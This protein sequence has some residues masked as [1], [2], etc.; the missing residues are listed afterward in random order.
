MNPLLTGVQLNTPTT[1][2]IITPSSIFVGNSVTNTF[3]NSSY[4][5]I[6]TANVTSNT[7]TLGTSTNAANGY[8]Y[9][10]N[11]FKM[12]WGWI[13]ANSSDGNVVFTS[14]FTTNAYVVTATSNSAVTTYQ[15][16]V[17][18]TNNTVAL[19]RTGNAT[20]TNVYWTAIGK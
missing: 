7:L 20:S 15:A 13:S 17:V 19:I 12:N 5:K 9:L 4:L 2:A 16:A 14:A 18:G 8:T 6:N 3:A 11:G 10:P 1:S